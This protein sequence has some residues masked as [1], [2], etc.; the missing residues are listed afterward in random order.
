MLFGRR[1]KK[2]HGASVRHDRLQF[3]YDGNLLANLGSISR[4]RQDALDLLL[5]FFL[6]VRDR[7]KTRK[8]YD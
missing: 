6:R 4:L 2:K 3:L 1:Q 8:S 5:F 7:R